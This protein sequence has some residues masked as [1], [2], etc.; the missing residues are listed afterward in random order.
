MER[1][2]S[3][4]GNFQNLN[5]EKVDDGDCDLRRFIQANGQVDKDIL[6]NL[7][8]GDKDSINVALNQIHW[9]SLRK[10]GIFVEACFE[11]KQYGGAK[12]SYAQVVASLH[13]ETNEESGWVAVGNRRGSSKENANKVCTIFVSRIPDES[14]ARDIW[15]FFKLGGDIKDI[16]LPKKRDKWNKRFGF[17]ITKSELEAGAIISNLKQHRGL[18]RILRMTINDP[19]KRTSKSF[20]NPPRSSHMKNKQSPIKLVENIVKPVIPDNIFEYTESEVDED[21]EDSF[22]N[23]YVC[24]TDRKVDA[25]ELR[26][27]LISKGLSNAKV[28]KANDFMF[29]VNRKDSEAWLEE[30]LLVLGQTFIRN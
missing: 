21:M 3:R 4:E 22:M 19:D 5:F 25:V 11:E 2:A 28:L 26:N 20:P 10:S 29:F 13:K 16:I 7:S 14:S 18:G 27:L 1:H 9:R 23:S 30:E 24:Y 15:E 12:K 6:D 17:V 8:G